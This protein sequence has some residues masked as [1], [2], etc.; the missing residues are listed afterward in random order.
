M[1]N[2]SANEK[3]ASIAGQ[4]YVATVMPLMSGA[5][6]AV[7]QMAHVQGLY[8]GLTYSTATVVTVANVT[9]YIPHFR[10]RSR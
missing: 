10:P 1:P 3:I 9:S 4:L 7:G 5:T 8:A 6:L 2:P